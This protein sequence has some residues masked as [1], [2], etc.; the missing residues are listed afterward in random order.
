[1]K[2]VY[3]CMTVCT[4]TFMYVPMYFEIINSK[5][6]DIDIIK[7]FYQS[8]NQYPKHLPNKNI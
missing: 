2:L 1:M 6:V 3:L 5:P 7:I 4:S 8:R